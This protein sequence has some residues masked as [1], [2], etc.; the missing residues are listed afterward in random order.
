MGDVLYL[1]R[2]V[3]PGS[4]ASQEERIPRSG[5]LTQLG[6]GFPSGGGVAVRLLLFPGDRNIFPSKDSVYI[7]FKGPLPRFL[8]NVEVK[9][10]QR[11]KAEWQSSSGT[12]LYA[13][14]LAV[15]E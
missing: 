11:L 1:S 6:V 4:A 10:D 9:K 8:L 3:G 14:I 12:A 7:D 13:P 2:R 5:R 15:I